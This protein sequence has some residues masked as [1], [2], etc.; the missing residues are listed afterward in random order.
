MRVAVDAQLTVGTATGIG[1]YVTGLVAGLRDRGVDV[2]ALR[3]PGSDP[4]RFDRRV[5]WDQVTLPRR[6]RTSGAALLHCASGTMPLASPG[7]PVVVTV[8]DVAWLRAQS[9][10]RSYAR[11]YFGSFSLARYRSAA[12]VF[13]DSR[14]S[15]SELLAIA[16][17]LDQARVSVVYPGVAADFC[18]LERGVGDGRTILVAGTVERRK[19][20]EV[21]LRALPSLPH[22]RVISVG[23]FTPYRDECE[24]LAASLG[25]SD[26][27]E[28]LGY[29]AREALLD[30]YARCAVV[31]VPSRYEGFGYALAQAL[32]AGVPCF[33]ADAAS[34]PEVAGEDAAVLPVDDV[35]AWSDALGRAL[36]GSEDARAASV[37]SRA[38]ARFGWGASVDCVVDAYRAVARV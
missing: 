19:N 26:R 38:I 31:A 16:P 29:V 1:E 12:A 36:S 18:A 4:W 6:V 3:D 33:A 9:H 11:R 35:A 13:V 27:I 30:L 25:V 17:D 23:P 2:V 7:V 22:A 8:H 10:A 15:R 24:A 32:C 20:L 5:V 34:L 21:V 28:Y 37:R 14:F